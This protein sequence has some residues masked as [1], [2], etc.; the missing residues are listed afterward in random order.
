MRF[1]ALSSCVWLLGFAEPTCTPPLSQGTPTETAEAKDPGACLAACEGGS[2]LSETDR[3]T[4]RLL[5]EPD[6]VQPEQTATLLTRFELC[7]SR[8]EPQGK[9]DTATCMLNCSEAAMSSLKL[10][11]KARAC[12]APCLEAEHSCRTECRGES[13]TNTETC[14]IQCSQVAKSCTD[15]CDRQPD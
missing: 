7:E 1:L 15:P 8:C 13:A 5:C 9:S 14:R 11:T 12:L 10:T 2:K 6:T 3:E 4:C